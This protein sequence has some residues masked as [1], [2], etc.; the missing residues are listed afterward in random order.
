MLRLALS[1]FALSRLILADFAAASAVDISAIE[2]AVVAAKDG[3]MFGIQKGSVKI[4]SY[5][6]ASI[7]TSIIEKR[8]QRLAKV[9]EQEECL[10]LFDPVV[11]LKLYPVGQL[12]KDVLPPPNLR[13]LSIDPAYVSISFNPTLKGADGRLRVG[14]VQRL[15]CLNPLMPS[16]YWAVI[17]ALTPVLKL[18]PSLASENDSNVARLRNVVCERSFPV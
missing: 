3:N 5:S 1:V 13:K 16:G 4:V 15:N 10:R 8:K 17:D 11:C 7:Y 6:P 9:A 2:S 14:K 18:V 12:D